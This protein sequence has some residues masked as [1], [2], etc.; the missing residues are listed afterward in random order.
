MSEHYYTEQPQTPSRLTEITA[1]LRGKTYRFYTDT[2]VFSRR[3]VDRG[4]QVLVEAM[5]VPPAA[6]VL[7]MGC[8]YG[9][10]GIV[11]ASLSPS[12]Q[13]VMV[14]VN[15]RAVELAEMNVRR[16]QL[17]NVQV[18]QGDGFAPVQ[19]MT[20]AAIYMNPP[21]RAGKQLVFQW[22][23]AARSHLDPGGTLWVVVQKKQGAPSTERRLQQLFGAE[24][25]VCVAREKGYHVF[26]SR[27]V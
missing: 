9:V 10:I 6:T 7:D 25:V 2:G 27:K 26:C 13:V 12:S 20:F 22:Y 23:E 19:G 3:Y 15:R 4:T 11:A 18:F 8:G 16:Y 17:R 24:H 5:E 21:F 14:D 1:T